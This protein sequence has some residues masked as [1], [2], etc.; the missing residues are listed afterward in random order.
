VSGFGGWLAAYLIAD[1]AMFVLFVAARALVTAAA[2]VPDRLPPFGEAPLPRLARASIVT[3]LALTLA[4]PAV[5]Y[6]L[7]AASWTIGIHGTGVITPTSLRVNVAPSGPADDAGVHDGDR[8]VSVGGEPIAR[9][10][11]IKPAL[12][13]HAGRSIELVVERDGRELRLVVP[14]RPPESS[15][16]GKLGVQQREERVTWAAAFERALPRP[17]MGIA[18][19]IE[20]ARQPTHDLV[21]P[22]AI[23]A[24]TRAEP[25]GSRV[26]RLANLA[27][28]VGSQAL[29]GLVVVALF[30]FAFRARRAPSPAGAAPEVF[31]VALSPPR[32][33]VRLGARIVDHAFVLLIFGVILGV[34]DLHLIDA[35]GLWFLLLLAIP[36]EAALL[37]SWGA[38]PGKWLL[39]VKVRDAL[40]AKLRFGQALHRAAAV[41]TF[42]V[43]MN[44]LVTFATGPLSF[45]RLR[46]RGSTYWDELDGCRV[47]HA[48]VR[49]GRVAVAVLIIVVYCVFQ[50]M[51]G[52]RT[53]SVR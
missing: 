27:A 14:P 31:G 21:G 23:T 50:L 2:R 51:V 9:F 42:G 47:D 28:L 6:L 53:L 40:G 1:V 33:W 45:R 35:V 26:P 3:R 7:V 12:A 38:T 4:G 13:K 52:I 22:I 10:T 34:L 16:A 5:V 17:L 39:G 25:D 37:A 8:I 32:P 30:L 43:G 41:W 49:G 11:D 15:W 19:R 24:V 36:L 46:R 18:A 48:E 29:E 44:Q 20:A